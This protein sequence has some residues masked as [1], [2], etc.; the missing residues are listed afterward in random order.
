MANLILLVTAILYAACHSSLLL[1]EEISPEEQANNKDASMHSGSSDR[2]TLRQEDAYQFPII[3]SCSLFGLYLAFKYIDKDLV[4]LLIGAYFAFAGCFALTFS[5]E[6]LIARLV[7]PRRPSPATSTPAGD[8]NKVM[9]IGGNLEHPLPIWLAGESPW[10]LTLEFNMAQ[11]I[12]FI[13]SVIICGLYLK[14]KTWY[15]NNVL[16]IC[17]CLQGIERFSLGT[18]KIGAILLI[19][20][21][22][23][24]IFW[25]RLL[26]NRVSN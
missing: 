26:L 11:L 18:Y 21:F 20:L 13:F 9:R 10:D 23:Y 17:F 14:T 19:G 1:L 4:N 2:E 22:F 5:L 6:P 24:D 16:G 12:S 8:T 3:G 7:F 25:V 15:L